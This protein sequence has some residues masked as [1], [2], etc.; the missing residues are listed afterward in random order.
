MIDKPKP[1]A[2][3]DDNDDDIGISITAQE[4]EEASFESWKLDEIAE[5]NYNTA[6]V[7]LGDG[8]YTKID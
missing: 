6:G 5:G 1:V 7:Y 3:L 8:V 2:I 4:I